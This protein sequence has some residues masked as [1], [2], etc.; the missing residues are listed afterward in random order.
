MIAVRDNPPLTENKVIAFSSNSRTYQ[1][2]SNFFP[3]KTTVDGKE[4]ATNEHW[5][6]SQKFVGADD[7]YADE[8]RRVDTAQKAKKMGGSRQH[9]LRKDFEQ[10]KEDIMYAGL[11]AKFS[12][13]A[14]LK[15]LLLDTGKT[16]LVENAP[17]DGYWGSG[18]NGQ[19]K[20]RMGALLEKLRAELAPASRTAD[21]RL[22]A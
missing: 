7:E 6:Q 2:F 18:R 5:Y 10:A 9:P 16:P 12:Q 17:W 19:G 1:E 14:R 20:N 13:H 3:A 11:V 8:V 4:Y 15:K 22:C 21:S